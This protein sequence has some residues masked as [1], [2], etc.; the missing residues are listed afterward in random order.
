M[1]LNLDQMALNRI[2]LDLSIRCHCDVESLPSAVEPLQMWWYPYLLHLFETSK[3]D[4]SI[5]K[6]GRMHLR[7]G[8]DL[9]APLL[10]LP[11]VVPF[12]IELAFIVNNCWPIVAFGGSKPKNDSDAFFSVEKISF[13]SAR[14]SK[15]LSESEFSKSPSSFVPTDGFN[16]SKVELIW[17]CKFLGGTIGAKCLSDVSISNWSSLFGDETSIPAEGFWEIFYFFHFF[18]IK[19]KIRQ[20]YLNLVYC[21]R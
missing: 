15:S 2:D 19:C 9:T 8:V 12:T 16:A 13:S 3:N 20:L 5:K 11:F 6:N 21:F 18:F 4:K 14:G 17:L 10:R 1:G 7:N